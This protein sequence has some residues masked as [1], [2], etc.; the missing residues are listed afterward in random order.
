MSQEESLTV[1]Q[2]L[3]QE[4]TFNKTEPWNKLN[5]TSKIQML[6]VFSERYG[7]KTKLSV[8]EI[9]LLKQ[10]FSSALDKK[11]LQ[12]TKEVIYNKE[13]QEVSDVPGLLFNPSNNTFYIKMDS[14]RQSTLKSLTPKRNTEKTKT[15][16]LLSSS[17]TNNSHGSDATNT[18]DENDIKIM[19]D[20]I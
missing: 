7:H 3:E 11:Q 1:D 14:K 13:T 12:K 9:K 2:I 16:T 8:K 5:K 18:N 15:S 17:L 4:K 10:F 6:H 19:D 20:N